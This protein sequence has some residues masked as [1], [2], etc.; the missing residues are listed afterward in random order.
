MHKNDS[1][2]NSVR[3]RIDAIV[4]AREK[5]E[6]M[7]SV[8]L[9]NGKSIANK[10]SEKRQRK[11]NFFKNKT[12]EQR[13]RAGGNEADGDKKR[14]RRIFAVIYIALGVVIVGLAVAIVVVNVTR[15][16]GSEETSGVIDDGADV[17]AD[18]CEGNA[19]DV[20]AKREEISNKITETAIET[21]KMSYDE[22]ISFIDGKIQEYAGTDYEFGMRMIKIYRLINNNDAEAALSESEKIDVG[23]L[24]AEQVLDFYRVMMRIYQA[25][26]DEYQ[27]SYYQDMY[28]NLNIALNGE[29]EEM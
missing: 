9:A 1:A 4:D 18:D 14:T 17:E 7:A 13:G 5:M 10:K 27:V 28:I 19:E 24:Y 8:N 21:E 12:N 26:G 20:E 6:S 2:G 3:Q 22:A 15:G 16:D 11:W 25:L 29:E 23:K